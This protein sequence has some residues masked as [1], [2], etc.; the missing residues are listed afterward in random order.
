MDRAL[1]GPMLSA[2]LGTQ[3][4]PYLQERAQR[5]FSNEGDSASGMWA[6]LKESTVNIRE[7]EG[8]PGPHPI[9]KRGGQL[10]RWITGAGADFAADPEGALMMWPKAASTGKLKDKI[11][12]AQ[13]GGPRTVPRPVVAVDM[14]DMAFLMSAFSMWFGTTVAQE[15]RSVSP[16]GFPSL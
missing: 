12:T 6:P 13:R 8:F 7:A 2:F 10:E 11:T 16:S 5:R 3:M 15:R 4:L 14:A 1:S 9:N